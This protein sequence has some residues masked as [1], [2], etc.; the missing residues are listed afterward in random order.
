[1]IKLKGRIGKESGGRKIISPRSVLDA[2]TQ[3]VNN[4]ACPDSPGVDENTTDNTHIPNRIYEIDE[5]VG[6]GQCG[7]E[8]RAAV[9]VMVARL[10]IVVTE[11]VGVSIAAMLA[12]LFS[13][14]SHSQPYVAP[15][16][17][18]TLNIVIFYCH[19]YVYDYDYDS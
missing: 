6:E 9:T 12:M 14:E 5:E 18:A 17:G 7:T 8:V 11:K 15:A 1:M 3:A 13:Q 16:V 10:V 19:D 4:P 2:Q